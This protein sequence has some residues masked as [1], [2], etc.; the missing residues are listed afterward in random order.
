MIRIQFNKMRIVG[1]GHGSLSEAA[2]LHLL[3]QGRAHLGGRPC[4]AY[5]G[6]LQSVDLL[7]GATLATG[8]D[9]TSVTHT[10][11]G[12]RREPGNE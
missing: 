4:H 3:Q 6:R 7:L 11:T 12:R 2:L 8:D 10:T 5:A 1:G 9:G